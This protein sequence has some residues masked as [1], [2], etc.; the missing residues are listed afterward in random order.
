MKN[1]EQT[2]LGIVLAALPLLHEADS[3]NTALKISGLVAAAFWMTVIFFRITRPL[4]PQKLLGISMILWIAAWTESILTYRSGK[5]LPPFCSLSLLVLLSPYFVSDLK[6]K[7]L[8][9]R[10]EHPNFIQRTLGFLIL[11]TYVGASRE[12]F[13]KAGVH[14]FDQPAGALFLIAFAG[15]LWENQP[16]VRCRGEHLVSKKA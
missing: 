3:F 14:F 7:A 10:V 9:S 6:P 5:G 8:D 15:W 4:F 13:K 2:F 1:S 11:L 16:G 12:I